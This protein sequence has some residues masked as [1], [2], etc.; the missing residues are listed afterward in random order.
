LISKHNTEARPLIPAL[1]FHWLTPFY[2]TIVR[3]TTREGTF[4]SALIDQA[5]IFPGQNI[6]DLG[7]GTGTLAIQV[8]ERHPKTIVHAVDGDPRVLDLARRK[9]FDAGVDIDFQEG[10]SY[11]L[12]YE[13]GTFDR[14]VSTLFFHHLNW[15]DKV[16]TVNELF[17]V[18]RPG[19]EL[20][21]ADWGRPSNRLMR[22]LFVFVQL[23]DGFETTAD[24]C[25]GRLVPL[26]ETAGFRDVE[27]SRR[28][29]TIFGT[30]RLYS[31]RRP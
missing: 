8:K 4:K 20:H 31:A 17:R 24:N 25:A 28:F 26:F 18:M 30:V 29:D 6:L 19:A 22:G 5:D 13:N 21:V 10:L 23:L 1:R 15:T 11:S 12:P 9:A 3:A 7:A 16:L 14:V 27:S 2:D